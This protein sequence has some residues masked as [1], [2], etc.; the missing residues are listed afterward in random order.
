MPIGE[1]FVREKVPD[2]RPIRRTQKNLPVGG[3]S[4]LYDIVNLLG[5]FSLTKALALVREVERS[6]TSGHATH[7]L[8]SLPATS[9]T[10]RLNDKAF[11]RFSANLG[12]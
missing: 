9:V 6:S 5:T 12:S 4:R 2:T 1:L 7:N 3:F 8:F 11:R 10:C